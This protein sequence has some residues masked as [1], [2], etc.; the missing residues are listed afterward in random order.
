MNYMNMNIGLLDVQF[1]EDSLK[2]FQ[3]LICQ[4]VSHEARWPAASTLMGK[5]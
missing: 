1:Y 4:H 2:C 5:G 3:L